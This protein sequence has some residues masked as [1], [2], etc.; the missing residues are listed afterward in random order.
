VLNLLEEV[1]GLADVAGLIEAG[2]DK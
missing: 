1:Q 2:D